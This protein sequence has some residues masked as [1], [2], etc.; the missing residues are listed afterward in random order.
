MK[1]IKVYK[2]NSEAKENLQVGNTSLREVE[3][4][5]LVLYQI[6]TMFDERI[7]ELQQEKELEAELDKKS[8]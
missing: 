5:F 2:L 6:A 4:Q 3:Q 8:Y 1:T 7:I